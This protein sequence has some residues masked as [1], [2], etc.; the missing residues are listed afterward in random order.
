VD[1][2]DGRTLDVINPTT[3]EL[4]CKV[5]RAGEADAEKAI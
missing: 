5:A 1:A 2:A 3:E 4:I